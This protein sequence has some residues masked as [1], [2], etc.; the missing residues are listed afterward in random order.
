MLHT[1]D[2]IIRIIFYG[3]NRKLFSIKEK[4]EKAKLKRRDSNHQPTYRHTKSDCELV[5]VLVSVSV[6][7]CLCESVALIKNKKPL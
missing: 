4:C 2:T 5:C 7:V 1:F 6:C 3:V